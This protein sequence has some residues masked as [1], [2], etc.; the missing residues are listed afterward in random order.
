MGRDWENRRVLVLFGVRSRN[1]KGQGWSR[2]AG[3]RAYIC[4]GVGEEV[5]GGLELHGK[6]NG[7]NW[8]GEIFYVELGL[9]GGVT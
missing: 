6:K 7:K 8:E 9:G 5:D 4:R 2:R 3:R 1:W